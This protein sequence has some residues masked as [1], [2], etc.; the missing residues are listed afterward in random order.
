[1]RATPLALLAAV[2]VLAATPAFAQEDEGDEMMPGEEGS[3]E[4]TTEEDAFLTGEQTEEEQAL[5]APAVDPSTTRVEDPDTAY[6]SVGARLRWIMVPSWFIGVFGV[7][8]KQA[9][10]LLVSKPGVG[11]E[12]TY[13]KDNFDITPAIWWAGLGWDGRV[14]FKEKGEPANSWEVVNNSLSAMLI[15]CDFIWSTSITDWFAITYGAGIGIGIPIGEIKRNEAYANQDPVGTVPC[16]GETPEPNDG[17]EP[18]ENYNEVY[19]KIK[20]VPWLNFLAGM[21]FKPHRHVAIY[22]DTGFGIGFVLGLR[23]GY[24]F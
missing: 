16:P 2:L 13:R 14:S 24:I 18:D 22:V 6:Y 8:I 23:A 1:M 17:C 7:N 19:E 21:R 4:E 5:A 3:A 9:N 12:F 15:S 11:A 10:H 20:V